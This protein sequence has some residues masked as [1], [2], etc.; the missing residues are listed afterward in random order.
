MNLSDFIKNDIRSLW[1]NRHS[2][3]KINLPL[4]HGN[5]V[6]IFLCAVNAGDAE[7]LPKHKMLT[8]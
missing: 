1:R 2:E 4:A 8:K 7:E 6:T 3:V 5:Q